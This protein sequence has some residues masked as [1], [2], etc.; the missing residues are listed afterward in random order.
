[1]RQWGMGV[2]L[3]SGRHVGLDG[4]PCY[5]DG[6]LNLYQLEY[7]PRAV[8]TGPREEQLAEDTF[9]ADRKGCWP[10]AAALSAFITIRANSFIRSSGTASIFATA[11]IRRENNG[12]SRP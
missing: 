10:R 4:K 1:M 2:Y 6:V 8:L 3:D 7:R 11:P 12:S 5:Y 9:A